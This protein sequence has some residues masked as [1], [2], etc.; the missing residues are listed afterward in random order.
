MYRCA[1]AALAATSLLAPVALH[2]QELKRNFPP[3]ALRG[4]LVLRTPSEATLNDRPVRL[5]PGFRMRGQNNMLAMSGG[6]LG[7]KLLVHYTLD[8]QG[9]VKDVW[10][11]TPEEASNT[12][13]PTTT[14]QA[15]RWS[16]DSAAQVW[17]KP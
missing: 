11:L 16:F 10:I 2:A 8:V 17:T 12:P 4:A 15:Q 14:E 13:W 5:A 7:A 3:E 1:F 9:L 6:L